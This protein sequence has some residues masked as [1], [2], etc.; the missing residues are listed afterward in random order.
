MQ[1]GAAV[2]A[3]RDPA[4]LETGGGAAVTLDARDTRA[5]IEALTAAVE[6]P[7]WIAELRQRSLRR[8]ADFSWPQTAQRTREVY[9]EAIRRF[10]FK[11]S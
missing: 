10:R 8:A 5:W 11:S 9:D 6:N 1:C 3:S 4:I 7:A 2:I